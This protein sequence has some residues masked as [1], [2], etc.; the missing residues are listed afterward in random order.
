VETR[1]EAEVADNAWIKETFVNN[2]RVFECY[3]GECKLSSLTDL[4]E[5]Q[6]LFKTQFNN[7]T[8]TSNFT[9]RNLSNG[10]LNNTTNNNLLIKKAIR[11]NG[12]GGN[13]TTSIF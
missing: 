1:T 8:G 9:V 10:P 13:I 5:N 11:T 2:Q 6:G 3:I 12:P 7:G 4:S